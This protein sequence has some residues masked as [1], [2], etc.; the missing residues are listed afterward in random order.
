[1][2]ASVDQCVGVDE[3]QILSLPRCE[4]GSRRGLLTIHRGPRQWGSTM[5]IRYRV[6]LTEA[7]RAQLMAMLSGGRHAARKLNGAEILL[8]AEAGVG[9]EEIARSVLVGGSTVYRT[10]RRFVEGNLGLALSEEA[11]PGAARKLSGKETALL[12]AT[13]CSAP[14]E[15]RKRWTLD[16]LA[17]AMVRLTGHEELSRETV[18]RRLA[19]GDLKPWR[20]GRGGISRG[21]GESWSPK[22]EGRDL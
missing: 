22:A 10:K 14:P 16:L 17:D 2:R 20:G 6:E 3:R 1:R 9:D 8:A 18:R 15:G 12:I 13:A 21:A 19:E 4:Q 11:R 7:E 5:N